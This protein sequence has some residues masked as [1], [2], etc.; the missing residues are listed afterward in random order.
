MRLAHAGGSQKKETSD[1]PVSIARKR[2][3]SPERLGYGGYRLLLPYDH[4]AQFLLHR[5]QFLHRGRVHLLHR[6][7]AHQRDRL[8]NVRLAHRQHPFGMGLTPL[9]QLAVVNRL[10]LQYVIAQHRRLLERSVARI[11]LAPA[12]KLLQFV[13]HG[14]EFFRTGAVLH[15]QPRAGF[16]HRVDGLVRQLSRRQITC[17]ELHRRPERFR[18]VFD[19]V[20]LLVLGGY[21]AQNGDGVVDRRLVHLHRLEPAFKRRVFFDGLVVF[22]QRGRT[23]ALEFPARQR[24]L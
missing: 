7:S 18:G 23:H 3:R 15:S 11:F 12:T 2:S 19:S 24:W 14:H 5:K 22:L 10:F 6:H 17:G 9:R 16:V 13:M 4:L 21:S 8:R 20:M 1:R